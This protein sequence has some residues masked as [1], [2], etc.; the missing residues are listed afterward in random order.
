MSCGRNCFAPT[1][2]LRSQSPSHSLRLEH[3]AH[4][5]FKLLNPTNLLANID[6][7]ASY[8]L[9]LLPPLSLNL[10]AKIIPLINVW[11]CKYGLMIE[12]EIGIRV[13]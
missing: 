8:L 5:A 9:V 11:N 12:E 13:Q 10:F 3:K 4:K 6:S 2:L 1:F 7:L